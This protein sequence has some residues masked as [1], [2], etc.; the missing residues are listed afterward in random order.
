MVT[1]ILSR[2]ER[3]EHLNIYGLSERTLPLVD[4]P[5]P[6]LRHLDLTLFSSLDKF[7]E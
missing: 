3:L 7:G 4:G 6:R 2:R 5:L 1:A